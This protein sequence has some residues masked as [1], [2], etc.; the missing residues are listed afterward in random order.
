[1]TGI[2]FDKEG[3]PTKYRVENLLNEDDRQFLVMTAQWFKEYVFAIVVDRKHVSEKVM[4]VYDEDPVEL[5]AWDP[6]G[7]LTL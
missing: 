3:N 2:S 6:L 5:P 1:M 7:N 4:K